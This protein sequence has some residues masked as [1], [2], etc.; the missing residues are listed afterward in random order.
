MKE[1]ILNSE[2]NKQEPVKM[3]FLGFQHFTYSP[4]NS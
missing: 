1:P 3:A 4:P 2:P